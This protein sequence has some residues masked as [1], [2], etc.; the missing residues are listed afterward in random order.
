MVKNLRFHVSTAEV[1]GSGPGLN[2]RARWCIKKKKKGL[3]EMFWALSLHVVGLL[4]ELRFIFTLS[5]SIAS[6]YG[7]SHPMSSGV[8]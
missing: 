3:R 6:E 4:V 8:S 1:M 2:P 5:N 7:H